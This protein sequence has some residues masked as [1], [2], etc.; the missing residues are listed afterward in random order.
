MIEFEK[1]DPKK[2]IIL[3]VDVQNDFCSKENFAVKNWGHDVSHFDTIINKMKSFL[4]KAYL[5]GIDILYTKTIYDPKKMPKS[6]R[7]RLGPVVGNYVAP[8]SWG[9]E[10]YKIK[11]LAEKVFIK[12]GFNAFMNP[13][14][15][16]Y[17]TSKE[18]ENI[19]FVGFN[20]NL[21]VESSA[22]AAVDLGFNATI[23]KDLTGT[24]TFMQL[25]EE[26]AL[27][28]FAIIFGDV[29]SSEEIVNQWNKEIK[30]GNENED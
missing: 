9:T 30:G 13:R 29:V 22:R 8:S 11:P 2:T 19:I 20:S 4:A 16:E 12:H 7:K 24:P 6:I 3:V 18:I 23:V 15:L 17:L 28:T 5:E 25:H 26:E 27:K 1:I 10:F 14:L 21:C